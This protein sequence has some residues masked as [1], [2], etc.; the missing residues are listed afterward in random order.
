MSGLKMKVKQG[1]AAFLAVC[2]M[3]P[4]FA[5]TAWADIDLDEE[6][7]TE[8]HQIE[9]DLAALE[10]GI[11]EAVNT[12][13]RWNADKMK[14]NSSDEELIT[15]YEQLFQ[16]P[17]GTN[18]VYLVDYK[19]EDG[20]LPVKS[21]MKIFLRTRPLE[22][23]LFEEEESIAEWE[24]ENGI[25]TA[26]DSDATPKAT[27][28]DAEDEREAE[29]ETKRASSSDADGYQITGEEEVTVLFK[30]SSNKNYLI[31][32][33]IGGL[34][35]K[36]MDVPSASI[37][38]DEVRID[39]P[40]EAP[41]PGEGGTP[42]ELPTESGA[43]LESDTSAETEVPAETPE[44]LPEE[45][46]TEGDSTEETST[47]ETSAADETLPAPETSEAVEET[48]A[49]VEETSDVAEETSAVQETTE[50]ATTEAKTEASTEAVT[51]AKTEAAVEAETEAEPETEAVVSISAHRVPRVAVPVAGDIDPAD[52][53]EDDPNYEE[54]V[55]ED[56]LDEYYEEEYKEASASSADVE[57]GEVYAPVLYREQSNRGLRMAA[58]ET[59]TAS[60]VFS[61]GDIRAVRAESPFSVT[62]YKYHTGKSGINDSYS[63]TFKF[64]NGGNPIPSNYRKANAQPANITQG[65]VKQTFEG[66]HAN[67]IKHASNNIF[68][69]TQGNISKNVMTVYD[70]ATVAENFFDYG[71]DGYYT[72][73]SKTMGAKFDTKTQVLSRNGKVGQFY[74]FEW[75]T[76]S[77][78]MHLSFDFSVL[79]DGKVNGKDMVFEFR[80]DDDTWI[81]LKDKTS[82]GTN[83]LALDIGGIHGLMSGT[84]NFATGEIVYNNGK[85]EKDA[86]K[87]AAVIGQR[88]T[89]TG[90]KGTFQEYYSGKGNDT[91][92]GEKETDR[93][94]KAYLYTREDAIEQYM[95]NNA[96]ANITQAE[97]A[98]ED[99]YF[100]FMGFD[101]KALGNYTLNFYILER[102]GGDSNCYLRFNIPTYSKD[103]IVVHKNV[104]SSEPEDQNK[105]FAF[106][107]WTG[108]NSGNLR[109][110]ETFTINPSENPSW[111]SGEK[112]LP[113][114]YFQVK[115]VDKKDALKVNWQ[116]G[117]GIESIGNTE[118]VIE[119]EVFRLGE[120]NV[121]LFTNLFDMFPI[122]GKQAFLQ[123]GREAQYDIKLLVGGETLTEALVD[124]T[125]KT[126]KL[127]NVVAKDTLSQY[128]DFLPETGKKYPTLTLT[129]MHGKE[130]TFN[131]TNGTYTSNGR[132]VA[133]ISGK[134]ITWNVTAAGE[135]LGSDDR[136]ILSFPVKVTG[137]T[138]TQYPNTG[139][140][141][142]GT[143]ANDS[144]YFSNSTAYVTAD[145]TA[146]TRPTTTPFPKP[147]V[148]PV[149][150]M[151]LELEKQVV[152]A[153]TGIKFPFVV[154]FTNGGN[155]ITAD[156]SEVTVKENGSFTVTGLGEG[157][158]VTFKNIQPNASYTITETIGEDDYYISECTKIET[159]DIIE[160]KPGEPVPGANPSE[161]IVSGTMDAN[162]KV[163]FTNT[164]TPKT[165]DIEIVKELKATDTEETTFVFQVENQDEKSPGFGQVF[166]TGITVPEGEL[167]ES[168]T[169]SDVP[170]I[171]TGYYQVTEEAH[172]R[173]QQTGVTNRGMITAEKP[174]VTFTN[175]KQSD[176]YFSS[177]HVAVN[178]IVKDADGTYG[179]HTTYP[180]REPIDPPKNPQQLAAILPEDSRKK[181]GEEDGGDINK[182]V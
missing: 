34:R 19:F 121:V 48:S 143:H 78:G 24:K 65:L 180:G 172:M 58:Q 52:L 124:G 67:F 59:T 146:E 163:I 110:T 61:L 96:W 3:M 80:G 2:M 20:V 16:D 36:V 119:T 95:K 141:N 12:N 178:E 116:T 148:R 17:D 55:E 123:E 94:K 42:G 155:S 5:G 132:I 23:E 136:R 68:P 165:M 18:P 9:L 76:Y 150:F 103:E 97:T 63:P 102:G 26:T 156:G 69:A 74:P 120:E 90:T 173:Y 100:Q 10:Q 93:H 25:E 6:I 91:T 114:T 21:D 162:K 147:V 29:T 168:V 66:A 86:E 133:T 44:S 113:G 30:N 115:E 169:L 118:E 27:P 81:Y 45:S 38:I 57:L 137:A 160:G 179:F 31:R 161:K 92:G 56:D 46:V 85:A 152:G 153:Q 167:R 151:S 138:L 154:T 175:A 60:M 117:S 126:Y 182:T 47:E 109:K 50:A 73:D 158:T 72:F 70:R 87:N 170:V 171:G 54:Y 144:G 33:T 130:T 40:V 39:T 129:D 99:T 71:E 14:F 106:E 43:P 7:R 164:L 127:K 75:G 139:D 125:P 108:T 51:E 77:F 83:R 37:L 28:S 8:E 112:Y 122:V 104:V 11:R 13:Q 105:D 98:V 140:P 157:N 159:R 134:T 176:S 88:Y 84:M 49:V 32:L 41:A 181:W 135:E 174:S 107:L 89:G 15:T 35:F 131:T 128:V 1:V 53:D 62:M 64:G 22:R 166:Y 82:G 142:T 177:T 111:K 149:N 101:R 79:S 4:S 145:N